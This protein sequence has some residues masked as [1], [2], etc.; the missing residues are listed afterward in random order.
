LGEFFKTHSAA[1]RFRVV[2]ASNDQDEESFK[3]YFGEHA[4]DLAL[5]F[6]SQRAAKLGSQ[7]K[8]KG[9]PCLLVFDA[10]TG[11]LITDKGTERVMEHADGADFPWKPKGVWEILAGASLTDKAGHATSVDALVAENDVI[12]LYFSAHW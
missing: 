8:V 12:G 10:A 4:W 1:K 2:F 7:F 11:E 9:I 5:P 6:G 3:K